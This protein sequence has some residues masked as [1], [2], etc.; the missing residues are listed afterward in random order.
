MEKLMKRMK[1]IKGGKILDI[2]TGRGE[3]IHSLMNGLESYD[4]ILG[5][6]F[7]ARSIEFAQSQFKEDSIEFAAA[8]VALISVG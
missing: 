7:S 5:I 1:E 2:A 8:I 4:S 6:D 3:F